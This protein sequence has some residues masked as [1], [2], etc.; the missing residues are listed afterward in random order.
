MITFLKMRNST[1]A[2]LAAM[3]VNKI[4]FPSALRYLSSIKCISVIICESFMQNLNVFF[5]KMRTFLSSCLL[6]IF[7]ALLHEMYY[8][9]Y[10]HASDSGLTEHKAKETLLRQFIGHMQRDVVPIMNISSM[11]ER[12]KHLQRILHHYFALP[13]LAS[14]AAGSY[15]QQ[16]DKNV[17]DAY[18]KAFT[19]DLV[20]T[21]SIQFHDYP[22]DVFNIRQIQHPHAPEDPWVVTTSVTLP[23]RDQK[24]PIVW[25]IYQ[26]EDD[27]SHNNVTSLFKIFNVSVNG[28]NIIAAK[29]Q[30]Y[31]SIMERQGGGL[32]TLVQILNQ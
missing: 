12:K 7:G 27:S 28:F 9:T 29:R 22:H 19:H 31:V 14:F 24:I 5:K 20:H 4:I 13:D 17:R 21:Y 1:S 10:V 8:V 11:A 15:W 6:V 23:E 30:E 32:L 16:A 25:M 2:L 18:I 3:H 26:V